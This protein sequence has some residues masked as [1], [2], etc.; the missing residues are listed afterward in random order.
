MCISIPVKI[1][2][3]KNNKAVA[4]FMGKREEF[5]IQLAKDIK[6]NDYALAS[7]GFIIKKISTKEADEIFKIIKPRQRRGKPKKE[8]K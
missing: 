1:L 3:L 6:V 2:E 4:E 8:E 5:D 7:N